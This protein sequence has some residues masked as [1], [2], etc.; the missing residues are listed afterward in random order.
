MFFLM[1]FKRLL[2]QKYLIIYKHPTHVCQ[3]GLLVL[4]CCNK[5]SEKVTKMDASLSLEVVSVI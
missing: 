3:L 1:P 4:Y 5:Y 2:D